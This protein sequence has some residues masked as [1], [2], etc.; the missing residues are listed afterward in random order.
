MSQSPASSRASYSKLLLSR[1]KITIFSWLMRYRYKSSGTRR[2]L[3]PKPAEHV[4][5]AAQYIGIKKAFVYFP[6]A[7]PAY[8]H[9]AF[10]VCQNM[11]IR[12][13]EICYL[14]I[15]FCRYLSYKY[16]CF[17]IAFY[18]YSRGLRACTQ[19]KNLL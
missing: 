18:N 11:R 12:K 19:E 3:Q 13:V 7:H 9:T 17:S 1:G 14:S 10:S 4:A 5:F 15:S 16:K 8:A 6:A 2:T